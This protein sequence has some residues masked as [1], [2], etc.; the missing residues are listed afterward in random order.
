MRD[1]L[2]E[3][4]GPAVR[5]SVPELVDDRTSVVTG[6]FD[7]KKSGSSRR[8]LIVALAAVV[9]VGVLGGGAALLFSGG[10][11]NK[12]A[13]VPAPQKS[14][15][16]ATEK[17]LPPPPPQ[18]RPEQT[19]PAQ[20]A[21]V[22]ENAGESAAET[23]SGPVKFQVRADVRPSG[24]F[25]IDDLAWWSS[26]G[27][28]TEGAH[29]LEAMGPGFPIFQ[30]N[31][32]VSGDTSFA[33]DLAVISRDMALGDLRASAK[34]ASDEFPPC[35]IYV[36][37]SLEG[38]VP[39]FRKELKAG[40]YEIELRPPQGYRTDSLEYLDQKFNGARARIRVPAGKR[41]FAKFYLTKR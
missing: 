4:G 20:Q 16:V 32:Y 10:D 8:G 18:T 1:A 22:T 35:D 29:K 7:M 17:E 25:R 5:D 37:G 27:R 12:A 34:T 36:N 2:A 14:D 13:I 30:D 40:L 6:E 26:S 19:Q 23:T 41:T 9:I 38:S 31:I 33:I 28:A 24:R 11:T 15:T 3:M 39:G 21:V